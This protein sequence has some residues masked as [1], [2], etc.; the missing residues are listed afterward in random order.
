MV[1][2]QYHVKRGDNRGSQ[3]MSG[4]LRYPADFCGVRHNSIAKGSA[5]S[6]NEHGGDQAHRHYALWNQ[7]Q[8]IPAE[9]NSAIFNRHRNFQNQIDQLFYTGGL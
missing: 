9:R 5:S 4:C 1:F 2:C 6:D 7:R 8:I 3:E